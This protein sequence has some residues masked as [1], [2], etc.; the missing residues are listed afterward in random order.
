MSS[1]PNNSNSANI[2][3]FN[4]NSAIVPQSAEDTPTANASNTK[5]VGKYNLEPVVTEQHP[6]VAFLKA[7]GYQPGDRVTGCNIVVN[8]DVKSATKSG[9]INF[10][11]VLTDDGFSITKTFYSSYSHTSVDI[12]DGL[13]WEQHE[14]DQ[15][16]NI[17]YNVNG[18][19]YKADVTEGRALCFEF[20]DLSFAEQLKVIEKLSNAGLEP[21]AIVQTHKSL[22]TYYALSSPL[23]IAKWSTIQQLIAYTVGSDPA[24]TDA[25]RLMRLPGFQFHK[26]YTYD[27]F[28]QDWCGI[29]GD[30]N[31]VHLSTVKYTVGKISKIIKKIG[32]EAGL[33]PFTLERFKKFAYVANVAKKH[34]AITAD[35]VVAQR[36]AEDAIADE[37]YQ[38]AKL[39]KSLATRQK[40]NPDID[41]TTAF[42]QDLA[43]VKTTN[44][45]LDNPPLV[46]VKASDLYKHGVLIGETTNHTLARKYANNY[47]PD[48]RREWATAQCPVC[49][50]R[51]DTLHISNRTGKYYC[52]AGCSH[53]DVQ[54]ELL[55]RAAA[56]GDVLANTTSVSAKVTG[57]KRDNTSHIAK[58]V[59][60]ARTKFT[61][62]P[63]VLIEVNPIT[64]EAFINDNFTFDLNEMLANGVQALFVKSGKGTGKTKF[65]GKVTE[66]IKEKHPNLNIVQLGHLKTLLRNTC[67]EYGLVNYEDAKKTKT[68]NSEQYIS[69]CN[70]TFAKMFDGQSK[71]SESVLI[72]DEVCQVVN[73]LLRN[74]LLK[75]DRDVYLGKFILF[76]KECAFLLAAD[77]DTDDKT[78][79]FIESYTTGKT[80]IIHNTWKKMEEENRSITVTDDFNFLLAEMKKSFANGEKSIVPCDSK[81]KVK[82][83]KE[84][85]ED[86]VKVIHG[87]N[88]NEEENRDFIKNIDTEYLKFDNFVYNSCLGTGVDLD[89]EHYT[90]RYG[91]FGG[92]NLT[93]QQIAQMFERYREKVESLIYVNN[94]V[95]YFLM[96]EDV[97]FN[98]LVDKCDRAYSMTSAEILEHKENGFPFGEIS[99]DILPALQLW[100]KL[101]A[102]ANACKNAPKA[103]LLN[104]LKEDGYT[105]IETN[106]KGENVEEEFKQASDKVKHQHYVDIANSPVLEEEEHE[107]LKQKKGDLTLPQKQTLEKNRQHKFYNGHIEI[108]PEMAETEATHNII[109]G[110]F[111]LSASL[112]PRPKLAKKDAKEASPDFLP[113]DRKN[114]LM[115]HTIAQN[116]GLHQFLEMLEDGGEFTSN[117]EIAVN[118]ADKIRENHKD[119]KH[120]LGITINVEKD[121]N[122]KH[123]VSNTQAISDLLKKFGVHLTGIKGNK[124]RRYFLHPEL[125]RNTSIGVL[126]TLSDDEA[127]KYLAPRLTKMFEQN[128]LTAENIKQQFGDISLTSELE[129]SVSPEIL[130]QLLHLEV[131]VTF[132][133]K[134]APIL[135]NLPDVDDVKE[136]IVYQQQ[137]LNLVG[138][139]F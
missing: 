65:L 136:E 47:N 17:Y 63:D 38:R 67:T 98:N 37:I 44:K 87:D 139:P 55:D 29:T 19:R 21:T 77:A 7:L 112:K 89:K 96:D 32:D 5:I 118:F 34:E 73:D 80:F 86:K 48:G 54:R 6:A 97:I 124:T 110:I 120:F 64:R 60:I 57:G 22:H 134:S 104:T 52:Q 99:E 129:N 23:P 70:M 83:I 135:H 94:E 30:V 114:E 100:A 11:G 95:K 33:Q 36:F 130:Q 137:A 49:N 28:A 50:G 121:K 76:V 3:G 127:A 117:D 42:T 122:G 128:T 56:N 2:P 71:A 45:T 58:C 85:Y 35:M 39:Y 24:I 113:Y 115:I 15:L 43:K 61:R 105:I 69:I 92:H 68:L 72:L 75:G 8:N 138:M 123:K 126:Q 81:Q 111:N 10:S 131:D 13:G 40:K 26:E 20:D 133:V 102:E 41:P 14:N 4:S 59:E 119:I 1:I 25:A 66:H 74:E 62:T 125:K 16:K 12:P 9:T 79:D 78:I 103:T 53:G 88:N 93:A 27:P 109:S 91:I 84:L 46:Q 51:H 106:D 31:L 108:T 107:A 18:G 90:K 132:W 116:I 101:E 82:T